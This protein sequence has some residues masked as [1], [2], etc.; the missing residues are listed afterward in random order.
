MLQRRELEE[1]RLQA[2]YK[3][4]LDRVS[5]LSRAIEKAEFRLQAQTPSI[6]IVQP[7]N[8]A[9]RV[10]VPNLMLVLVV[11]LFCGFLA[12]GLILYLKSIQW[13][14]PSD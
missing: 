9:V 6:T 2:A 5:F 14:P 12:G 10:E 1:K 4:A 7:A 13:S 8:T 3:I 11:A